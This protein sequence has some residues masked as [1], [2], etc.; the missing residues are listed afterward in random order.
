MTKEL[1][2][3]NESQMLKTIKDE[4]KDNPNLSREQKEDIINMLKSD[5]Y[6]RGKILQYLLETRNMLSRPAD[7]VAWSERIMQWS[8]HVYGDAPI[9]TENININVNLDDHIR[10]A[11]LKRKNKGTV[12]DAEFKDDA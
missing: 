9:K 7:M 5:E 10:E 3:M 12:I 6:A 2:A 4:I 11:Y 1:K 8:K